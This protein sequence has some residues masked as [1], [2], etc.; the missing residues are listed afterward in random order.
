MRSHR[1]DIRWGWTCYG[2]RR[3]RGNP[4]HVPQEHELTGRDFSLNHTSERLN[5][6][7]QNCALRLS[8]LKSKFGAIAEER[9]VIFISAL[10]TACCGSLTGSRSHEIPGRGKKW[11]KRAHVEKR[12]KDFLLFVRHIRASSQK[13]RAIPHRPCQGSCLGA[14]LRKSADV[15]AVEAKTLLGKPVA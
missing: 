11:A 1:K 8:L 5:T 12:I 9:G 6:S 7:I 3:R 15:C 14:L 13:I 10:I 2:A 4:I